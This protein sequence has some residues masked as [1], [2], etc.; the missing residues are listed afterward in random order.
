[1]AK[2]WKSPW[3]SRGLPSRVGNTLAR[4]SQLL[5]EEG[6]R[7]HKRRRWLWPRLRFPFPKRFTLA[8]SAPEAVRRPATPRKPSESRPTPMA[9]KLRYNGQSVG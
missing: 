7:G 4:A 2:L 3:Q 1:M 6:D 9:A 5:D 8:Q